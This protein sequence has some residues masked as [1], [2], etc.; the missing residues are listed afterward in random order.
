MHSE[1]IQLV[2]YPLVLLIGGCF[3]YL[4]LRLNPQFS[5]E[6]SKMPM[7]FL[8]IAFTSFAAT[9][10]LDLV[11]FALVSFN[12][13]RLHFVGPLAYG[14]ILHRQPALLFH[15]FASVAALWF[16]V[17]RFANQVVLCSSK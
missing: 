9:A 5:Q 16:G 11:I 1:A 10:L 2:A 13:S 6:A 14:G 15:F 4:L 7:I 8:T 17:R 3:A 12:F